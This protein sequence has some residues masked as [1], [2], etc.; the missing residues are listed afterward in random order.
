MELTHLTHVSYP[1]AW[2]RAS[3]QTSR[4]FHTIS[5][6]SALDF[7]MYGP[8]RYHLSYKQNILGNDR[9]VKN[10]TEFPLIQNKGHQICS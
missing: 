9:R 7:V 6:H 8:K 5:A 4:R 3:K 10:I 1:R 2:E